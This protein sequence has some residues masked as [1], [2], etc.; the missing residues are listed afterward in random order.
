MT[1]RRSKQQWHDLLDQQE[2]SGLSGAA[3]CRQQG[4]N[5]KRF[6]YHNRRR[7]QQSVNPVPS[8][9]VR[10]SLVDEIKTEH[11]GTE[12]IRFHYGRCALDNMLN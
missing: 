9:F 11:R 7:Q 1:Q 3:F 4:I 8:S 6:Y 10:A 5:P 2:Q 12:L